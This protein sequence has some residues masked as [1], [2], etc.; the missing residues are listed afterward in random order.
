MHL[1]PLFRTALF[2]LTLLHVGVFLGS[3]LVLGI[4][5]SV[6]LSLILKK[7]F[8]S[9]VVAE[10]DSLAALSSRDQLL[11]EVRGREASG[12]HH[13]FNYLVQGGGGDVIAGNLPAMAA[14]N[15]WTKVIL[16]GGDLDE[17]AIARGRVLPDGNFLLVAR[18]AQSLYDSRDFIF[19]VLG[20]G[21]GLALPLAIAGGIATSL[22]TLRRIET[23][24]RATIKIRRGDMTERDPIELPDETLLGKHLL[25]ASLSSPHAARELPVLN[26]P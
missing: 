9:E 24:N 26:N 2:R 21:L 6:M 4:A 5:G 12:D 19:Q 11:A 14:V 10:L 23:I 13:A 18:D 25:E 15:G 20:W 3:A 1:S 16:P 17:P 7:E 22:A 8:R